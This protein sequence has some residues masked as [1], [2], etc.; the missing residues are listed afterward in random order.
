MEYLALG[1]TD[2]LV[3]RSAFGTSKLQALADDDAVHVL[4]CA[5][6]GGINFFD[7]GLC[8]GGCASILGS[9]FYGIRR[10]IFFSAASSAAVPSELTKDID[11]CLEQLRSDYVDL[12]QIYAA[13]DMPE[14]GGADGIYDALSA[15]KKAGKVH[16]IGIFT[17]TLEVAERALKSGLYETICYPFDIY[18]SD[19]E[20]DLAKM[21]RQT[22][23][24]FIAAETAH[25]KCGANIPLVF[26]FIRQFENVVPLWTIQ[27]ED[28]AQ[29]ILYFEAH[30][31]VA[32]ERF[33]AEICALRNSPV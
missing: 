3:S 9:A 29:Q 18:S 5:Y 32:D 13:A 1:K 30:P 33:S 7:A 28:D 17:E 20:C 2:L 11:S 19:R 15:A 27:S 22:E 12:F 21:C 14:K 26:G 25:K 31:P 4:Q 23:T 6:D 10:E 16:H 24:G 8:R